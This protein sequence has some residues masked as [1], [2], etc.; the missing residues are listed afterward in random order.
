MIVMMAIEVL[1]TVKEQPRL[2]PPE[3]A[4]RVNVTRQYVRNIL[5]I[6]AQLK[7][8]ETPARGVYLITDLGETVLHEISEGE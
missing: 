4:K 3:I 1:K 7:L 8:V 5:M 6:L 2:T